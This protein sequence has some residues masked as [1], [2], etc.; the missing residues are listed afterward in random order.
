M[1]RFNVPRFRMGPLPNKRLLLA[2]AYVLEELVLVRLATHASRASSRLAKGRVA[3]S[4]N[5]IR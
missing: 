1:T 2:G 4:R 3:R 5:L